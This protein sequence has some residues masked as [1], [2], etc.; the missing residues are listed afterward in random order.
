VLTEL[1]FGLTK[2]IAKLVVGD[3]QKVS[4]LRGARRENLAAAGGSSCNPDYSI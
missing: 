4:D 3:L 1:K 2:P